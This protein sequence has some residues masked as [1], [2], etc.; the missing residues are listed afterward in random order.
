MSGFFRPQINAGLPPKTPDQ[1]ADDARRAA[2]KRESDQ[3][4]NYSLALDAARQAY[5][6]QSRGIYNN[7]TL[8]QL[9]LDESQLRAQAA[10]AALGLSNDLNQN[11]LAQSRL[12]GDLASTRVQQARMGRNA[13]QELARLQVSQAQDRM[14]MVPNDFM[15]TMRGFQR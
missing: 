7:I 13:L 8:A 4:Y 12:T 9:G 14:Q 15:E 6:N 2:E 1:V 11:R 3:R 5:E 10:A